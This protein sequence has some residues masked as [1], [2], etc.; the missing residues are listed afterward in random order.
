MTTTYTTLQFWAKRF[1]I[2]GHF[3]QRDYK[4]LKCENVHRI[5]Q[6]TLSG[7]DPALSDPYVRSG[8]F[9]GPGVGLGGQ[10]S[11]G[12]SGPPTKGPKNSIFLFRTLI[13]ACVFQPKRGC[14]VLA[15][16]HPKPREK[17]LNGRWLYLLLLYIPSWG[18]LCFAR[19]A[20]PW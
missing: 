10:R 20:L 9:G 1:T 18:M 13:Q 6:D 11:T 5:R 15:K 14:I 17:P 3:V 2:S 12:P 8:E 19:P 7:C 16:N 4:W